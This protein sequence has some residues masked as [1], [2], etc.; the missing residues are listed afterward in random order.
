MIRRR[1]H[2]ARR[3]DSEVSD[4]AYVLNSW[5]AGVA[6]QLMQ[7]TLREFVFQNPTE[8]RTYFERLLNLDDITTLIQN[9]VVGDTGLA[10]FG[11]EHGGAMLNAWNELKNLLPESQ[12]KLFSEI[13]HCEPRQ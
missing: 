9:A 3:D 1:I 4:S 10:L 5:F 11:R 6:P 12:S 7:H 13:E 8:R 2:V